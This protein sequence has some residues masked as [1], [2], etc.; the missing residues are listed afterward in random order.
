MNE[1]FG[2]LIGGQW[3]HSVE[4]LP[5]VNPSDTSDVIGQYAVASAADV[6]EA[7]GLARAAG[8]KWAATTPQEKADRLDAIGTEIGAR[9]ADLARQ[10]AREEGKTLREAQAEVTKAAQL[11]RFF[12]GEAVRLGG[13]HV[14]S[15]RPGIDVDVERRPLGVVALVTPW[16]FPLSIPAW[17][18]APALAFGNAVILK[19]SELTNASAWSLA[20][21][22]NRHLPAGVFQLLMGGGKVGQALIG[23]AGVEAVSFTGSVQTGAAIT[24]AAAPGMKLQLEM[25]GKN[26]LIVMEDA[27]LALAVDC[28]VKGAFYSS[29]QR[30]TASSRLIVHQAV[31]ARFIDMLT[32]A[33][34]PLRVGH[35]LDEHTDIGPLVSAAQLERVQGYVETGKREGAR[36]LFG[37]ERVE[38]R[39]KGFYLRP[40]LFVDTRSQ[41]RINQEEIFGPVASV[42]EVGSLDEAIDVGNDTAF[43]LCAGM[44]TRSLTYARQFRQRIVAGMTMINLPTVGTDYHVPFGGARASSFGPREC[45]SGA[46]EFYTTSVTTYTAG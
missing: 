7:V 38:A 24:R 33:A 26:P 31:S 27:D 17:K 41:H 8:R 36:L 4:T 34:E 22:V 46:R 35:A 2:N 42:I 10:L 45:G 19:P 12:A 18:A 21:I 1:S 32:R 28:A 16:N 29:G 3:R 39:T 9:S 25:G 13:E 15:I 20:D 23:S 6:G 5:D 11:F 37:A 30:C 44:F 40:A 14:R 43:G